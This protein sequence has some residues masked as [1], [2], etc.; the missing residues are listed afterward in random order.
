M[1]FREVT[2]EFTVW[3]NAET[4]T[5]PPRSTYSYLTDFENVKLLA[6][7]DYKHYSC[8]IAM[9]DSATSTS[10]RGPVTAHDI[11]TLRTGDA[12]MRFYITTVHDG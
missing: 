4:P 5:V 12:D 7:S 8:S 6:S 1:Q 10:W 9:A 11:N 2:S 3:Q